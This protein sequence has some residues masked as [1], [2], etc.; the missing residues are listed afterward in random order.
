M[1]LYKKLIIVLSLILVIVISGCSKSSKPEKGQK[2]DAVPVVVTT[3]E[4]KDIPL[5]FRTIGTVEEYSI[6]SVLSQVGGVISSVEFKEGQQV[7]KGELLFVIDSRLFQ[8]I[9][10]QLEANLAKDSA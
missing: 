2:K 9:I 10:H 5:Q 6:V 1:N 8:T 7:K 3:V 4:Q